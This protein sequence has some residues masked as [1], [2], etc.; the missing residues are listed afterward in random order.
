[1]SAIQRLVRFRCRRRFCRRTETPSQRGPH[2]SPGFRN[3]GEHTNGG[4]SCFGGVGSGSSWLS[5]GGGTHK[6]TTNAISTPGSRPS[7]SKVEVEGEAPS[8]SKVTT[9]FSSPPN[10]AAGGASSVGSSSWPG[11]RRRSSSGLKS[12]MMSSSPDGLTVVHVAAAAAGER[13]GSWAAHEEVLATATLQ[14]VV[15][16]FAVQRIV[17]GSA[18]QGVGTVGPE[19]EV[20]PGCAVERIDTC[21]GAGFTEIA[22]AVAVEIALERIGHVGTHVDGIV[23]EVT[24]GIGGVGGRCRQGLEQRQTG[25]GCE[26]EQSTQ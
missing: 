21:D 8:V 6:E 26:C 2:S 20:G 17:A 15:A 19:H 14:R 4:S 9:R 16:P 1:M 3:I 13:V 22:N 11:K 5:F 10:V 18:R 12:V 24:I 7:N 23:D 25:D